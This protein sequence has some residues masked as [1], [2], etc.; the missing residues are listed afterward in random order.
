MKIGVCFI[1]G[2]LTI[3]VHSQ[4]VGIGIT[5]PTRAKL[6]V[7][8]VAGAGFTSAIFGGDGAGISMQRNWPT[9]GF[10]QYNDGASKY[11][12]TGYASMLYLDPGSG[13]MALDML[14]TG[15]ANVATGASARALTIASNGNM[16]IRSSP[17]NMS[18]YV[19][20]AG[21]FAGAAVFSGS[22]N[23][24]YFY[25]GNTEDIYIRG[26]VLGSTIYLNDVGNGDVVIGNG[27]SYLGINAP[28]P[29]YPLEIRQVT[30]KGIILVEPSLGFANW[31]MLVANANGSPCC[32]TWL[33]FKY[34][35][36]AMS[37]I[38][39]TDGSYYTFSDSR[40]KKNI[41]K[42]P[43]LLDKVM[44][45][46]PVA[47]EMK[48]HNP[49]EQKSL[50]FIAQEV[51]SLFPEL[52]T[53]L[54]DSAT[55]YKGIDEVHALNYSGFGVLAIKAIQEQQQQITDLQKRMQLLEEKNKI[56]LELINKRN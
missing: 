3:A 45:L 36:S 23:S 27:S 10:N 6:Q 40:L 56:L 48:A 18:L 8:G 47:Y 15:S 37:F 11:M 16:A 38:K 14:N 49:G 52:V 31:E 13:T 42:L 53:V 35:G 30:G 44:Q 20:R 55:G 24:S 12:S 9:I 39:S 26:G 2:L 7:H 25:Y 33:G 46:E 50:G 54:K 1:A 34:N 41:Q 5:T 19:P 21:N 51:K 17:G 43:S 32:A 22:V 29:Q 28:D 4:N